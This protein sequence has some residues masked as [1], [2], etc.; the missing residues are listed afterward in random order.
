MDDAWPPELIEA[1]WRA[2]Y[3]GDPR[4]YT[5]V[6]RALDAAVAW[7][8]EH[9]NPAVVPTTVAMQRSITASE[10]HLLAEVV[11]LR[12]RLAD[13]ERWKSQAAA[14]YDSE[15]R[16][17]IE[18]GAR[19]VAAEARIRTLT[20]ALWAA[21]TELERYVAIHDGDYDDTYISADV[22]HE[23]AEERLLTDVMDRVLPALR[24]VLGSETNPRCPTCR[25]EF[26]YHHTDGLDDW[27]RDAWHGSETN[28]EGQQ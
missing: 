23:E 2:L 15:R 17:K 21:K 25:S 26:R 5:A 3:D 22:Q 24:A 6:K 16:E 10:E 11:A 7:R 20:E 27:C 28:R 14:K 1:S 12:A 13:T 19:L 9:G 18:R 4:G 8:D